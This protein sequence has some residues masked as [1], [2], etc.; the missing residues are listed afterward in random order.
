MTAFDALFVPAPVREAVS[1]RSWLEALLEVERALAAA[2]ATVGV[3]PQA[4]ADAIADACADADAFRWEELLGQGHAVGNPVEPL[5]RALRARVGVEHEAFVH[6]GA[7]SQ[8]VL[9]SAAMLVA[10]ESLAHVLGHVDAVA[11]ACAGLGRDHRETPMAA[12]TLLQQAVPTTFGLVAAGWLVALLD[13]RERLAELA[14]SGLAVQL[15]GAAGTLA[16]LGED[17]PRVVD[18]LA[19]ELDLTVPTLPWHTNR[20][21]IAELG[22]ALATAAGVCGKIGLDV[23][24][25]SQTE[26][27]EVREASGGGSSTMPQKRNPVRAT[28]ARACARLAAAHASVLQETLVQEHERAAGAWHAEWAALCGALAYAGGAAAAAAESLAGLHVDAQRMRVNLD[29]GGGL[30]L[31]ERIALRA[32][33][34]DGEGGRARARGRGRGGAVVPRGAPGRLSQPPGSRRAR[35]AA[36][37]DDLPRLGGRA[38]RPRARAVRR[39]AGTGD[40]AMT[41]H[42]VV[43]GDPGAP[44]VVLASSLGATHAM[45]EPQTGPLRERFRVVRCDRRG[46]GR[47][48]AVPGPTTIDDLGRDLVELLDALELE[49]VSF[50]GLSLGGLEGMWLALHAPE[51]V[52]RLVL[53]CTSSSF[54]PRETWTER[55]A[56]VRDEGLESIADATMGRWFSA[57]FRDAE[58]AVVTR[59]RE[60]LVSTPPRAT[61]RAATCSPTP[62]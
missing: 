35:R 32:R 16:A 37:P 24:L 22:A 28:L 45:W 36:R 14:G 38:R 10:R 8:D 40:R 50:C 20:V 55:A 18:E 56:T 33:G 44:T 53:A 47:S 51:R 12:R 34:D 4:A 52:D 25:L 27:A 39:G 54:A 30:V 43:D 15:G 41:L 17:G 13:A 31:A 57:S 61:S 19:R 21:R 7:T 62:I 42:H 59:F 2:G 9:D 49:R 23:V 46:H 3:V 26:V 58:P 1:G 48:P 5:V 11:A 29:A 6:L 60:M